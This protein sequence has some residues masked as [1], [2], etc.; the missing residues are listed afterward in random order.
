MAVGPGFLEGGG[1]EDQDFRFICSPLAE[2]AG[3][4]FAAICEL[5]ASRLAGQLCSKQGW[6]GQLLP[7]CLERH[8]RETNRDDRRQMLGSTAQAWGLEYPTHL[9]LGH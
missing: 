1:S 3:E 4:S 6:M 2:G 9:P 7:L 8:G 5:F